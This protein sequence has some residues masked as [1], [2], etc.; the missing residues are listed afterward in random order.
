MYVHPQHNWNLAASV[1]LGVHDVFF[2]GHNFPNSEF[3]QYV[4][5]KF[6]TVILSIMNGS[7]FPCTLKANLGNDILCKQL[8]RVWYNNHPDHYNIACVNKLYIFMIREMKCLDHTTV[9]D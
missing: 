6:D 3:H 7:V 4:Y 8:H 5:T 1:N 2:Y 9:T